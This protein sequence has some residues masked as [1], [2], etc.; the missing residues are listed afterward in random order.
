MYTYI[1]ALYF[2][3]T[4]TTCGGV[5]TDTSHTQTA[6]SPLVFSQEFKGSICTELE[7][8]MFYLNGSG[9]QG[10]AQGAMHLL[11]LCDGLGNGNVN[12]KKHSS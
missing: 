11:L 8:F 1:F 2:V 3:H 5:A 10:I 12:D 9:S 4:S 7:L 6:N